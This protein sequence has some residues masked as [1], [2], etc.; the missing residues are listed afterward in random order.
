[1]ADLAGKAKLVD[2]AEM[3]QAIDLL[4]VLGGDGTMLAVA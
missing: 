1:M 2:R 3:A 4:I